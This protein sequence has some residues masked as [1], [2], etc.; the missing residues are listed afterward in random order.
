MDPGTPPSNSRITSIWSGTWNRVESPEII[1]DHPC[2]V[3]T[4]SGDTGRKIW[5]RRWVR[6][7]RISSLVRRLIQLDLEAV[8][9]VLR[10]EPLLLL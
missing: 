4:E 2:P 6:R 10:G 8:V 1:G 7:C 3:G 5:P 9:E